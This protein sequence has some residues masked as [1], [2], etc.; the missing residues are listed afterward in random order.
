MSDEEAHPQ[1]GRNTS[2]YVKDAEDD[3]H[4]LPV[5]SSLKWSPS[6]SAHLTNWYRFFAGLR[7]KP[8]EKSGLFRPRNPDGSLYF[9]ANTGEEK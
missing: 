2:R 7:E 4:V 1:S 3:P 8:P 6:M 9:G 5:S